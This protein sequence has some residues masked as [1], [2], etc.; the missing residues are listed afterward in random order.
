MNGAVVSHHLDG[1]RSG[2][3][4]FNDLL[5]HGLDVPLLGIDALRSDPPANPL[6]SF[7]VSELDAPSEG[8]VAGWLAS[9]RDW[10][11]FLH[12]F[13]GLELERRLVDGAG[14]VYCGNS[15]IL[16]QLGG[17]GELC[18][19]PSLI[20]DDRAYSPTEIIVFSFGMAHKLRTDMFRRLRD[21]L[22]ASG[23]TYALYVS[24]ANHETAS[25][26]DAEL[27]FEELHSIFPGTLYFLGNLSDVGIVNQLRG[28]TFFAT[29]FASGV[30][31]NNTSVSAALELGAV[32]V[33]NLDEYSPPE[34][35]HMQN[36]IDITQCDGLPLDQLTLTRLS[37][38][39]MET[40]RSRSWDRL[41]AQLR[42]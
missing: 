12:V 17:R 21:L 28:A 4:R 26:R 27:V 23:R 18:W 15:E 39:A 22:D 20:L 30:R 40:A 6:L 41:L 13:E 5:A 37:V 29:F 24:A 35:T 14:R 3:A 38:G 2:V 36:V 25:L 9:A 19:A 34:F 7:K 1:F 10:D 16:E 33:T 8:I 11:V 32:V 31:A 42:S